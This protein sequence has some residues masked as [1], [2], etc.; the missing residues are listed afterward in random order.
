MRRPALALAAL[1]APVLGGCQAGYY[2]QLLHGQYDLLSRREPIEA[3]LARPD[4]DA[5][6]ASRLRRAQDARD[7]AAREL[8][9]PDNGS[10]RSYA[11]LGR[12][13][14]LWNVFAAP[15]LS[16]APHTWC[17]PMVGCLAY[18]GYYD[19]ARAQAEAAA[20]RQS[21]LEAHVGGVPAYST[22]GWFDDPLLNT[23]LASDETVVA[24]I[25]HELAHQA[26]FAR[27]DTAFSES[28]ATFVEHEGLRRYFRAEPGR[29]AALAARQQRQREFVA[30]MLEAR[31]RLERTYASDLP[32]DEKRA[33][34]ATEFGRL[35]EAYAAARARWGGDGAYDV[36]FEGDLD[37]ARLLPFG[38]Y[39]QWVPAF[40]A[41]FE[42]A[43]GDWP[44]FL[45][46]V[47]SLAGLE[48]GARARR[49]E[50]LAQAARETAATRAD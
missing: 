44:A 40:A 11:D 41:L 15:E 6:L 30:L 20:L 38:L 35:R 39:H 37:N 24:T 31:S 10:Y 1:A 32:V 23:V 12:P 50:A 27:G 42:R 18:R 29:L 49:L 46:E 33:R 28:F 19:L 16:L 22:L 9:L 14:A 5:T 43:G 17:Y 48:A 25:F 47:G 8:G 13:F 3:V 7:F 2:A 45:R 21:G 36:W 26:V 4:T 34:K